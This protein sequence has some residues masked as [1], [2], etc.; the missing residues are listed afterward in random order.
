MDGRDR[1]RFNHES[2]FERASR[3]STPAACDECLA[4]IARMLE[5]ARERER[6]L[7]E[8]AG[9]VEELSVII[10]DLDHFEDVDDA[11]GHTVGDAVLQ[12]IAGLLAGE[13]RP[14]QVAIRYGAISSCSRCRALTWPTLR[15]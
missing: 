9:T 12:R 6:F 14:E 8:H 15:R 13:T 7:D 1:R 3:A 4:E 11:L 10:L 2:L 5:S